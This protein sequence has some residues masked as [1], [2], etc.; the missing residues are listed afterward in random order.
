MHF[1]LTVKNDKGV[2]LASISMILTTL[3]RKWRILI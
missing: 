3:I 2:P 1:K